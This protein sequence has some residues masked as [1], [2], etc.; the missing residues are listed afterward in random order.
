MPN[1]YPESG[2]FSP[3]SLSPHHIWSELLKSSLQLLCLLWPLT[4]LHSLCLLEGPLKMEVRFRRTAAENPP[5]A[6]H[7]LGVE[8]SLAVF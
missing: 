6:S 5:M 2:H 7:T 1:L 8:C 4:Y 3:P